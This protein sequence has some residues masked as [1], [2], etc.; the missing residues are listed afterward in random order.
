MNLSQ[1]CLSIEIAKIN[2]QNET[3]AKDRR[4]DSTQASQHTFSRLRCD[5]INFG[6]DV[7]N[8]LTINVR[9]TIVVVYHKALCRL[10]FRLINWL[11]REVLGFA[12]RK[13]NHHHEAKKQHEA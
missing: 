6:F 9:Q 4:H 10:R 2:L 3:H 13:G 1:N 11:D 12:A 5:I 8:H 7:S